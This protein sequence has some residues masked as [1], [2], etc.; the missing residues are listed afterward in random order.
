MSS[1][2]ADRDGFS[3][4]SKTGADFH[5]LLKQL[6][7]HPSQG[8]SADVVL[9]TVDLKDVEKGPPNCDGPFNLRNCLTSSNE[10]NKAAGIQPK[11]VGVIW[12]NLQVVVGGRIDHKVRT[13]SI[14]SGQTFYTPNRHTSGHLTASSRACL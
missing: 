10:A 14:G 9:S 13:Y 11:H 3:R 1:L 4:N 12:E 5:I 7:T 6:T 2:V 8:R